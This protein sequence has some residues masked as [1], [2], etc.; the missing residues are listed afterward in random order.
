MGI[1]LEG[2]ALETFRLRRSVPSLVGAVQ[3]PGS[4]M[5]IIL[6]PEGPTTGG[7]AQIGILSRTSWTTLAGRVPG[8]TIRFDW[9][10][11]ENARKE[12]QQRQHLFTNKD[13][14]VPA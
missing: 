5:P 8:S 6:G 9:I 14:W 2:E 13:A 1:R 3:V 11:A 4:G 7:Y 10:G 12:W